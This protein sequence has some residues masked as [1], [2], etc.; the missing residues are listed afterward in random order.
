MAKSGLVGDVPP[1]AN[2]FE[3]HPRLA[4]VLVLSAAG[5]ILAASTEF[6]L[7]RI[8]STG[9]SLLGVEPQ[10]R[11]LTF[12]EYP[13]SGRFGAMPANPREVYP[14]GLEQRRYWIDIDSN[15]FLVP[16]RM[17]A[18]AALEVVFLG[19]STTEGLFVTPERRFPFRVGRMLED[20]LG[21][22]VN[23]YNGGRSGNVS[24]HAV[25]AFL[26][27]VAPMRP[28]YVILMEN[29]NDLAVLTH[30]ADYWSAAS[31]RPFMKQPADAWREDGGLVR[32]FKGALRVLLPNRYG[33]L[34]SA[35]TRATRGEKPV[36]EFAAVRG[37][38][39]PFDLAAAEATFQRGLETF[40]AVA[41]I[42]RTTPVLMT[43]ANRLTAQPDPEIA[44]V[45][46]S[47]LQGTS[48][49]E[50]RH[51]YSRFNDVI[52]RVAKEQGV[53]LVDLDRDLTPDRLDMYDAVHYTDRGSERAAAVIARHLRALEGAQPSS[54]PR[55]DTLR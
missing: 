53:P 31:P 42:W 36:D 22:S 45:W 46:G 21:T 51:R 13:V 12:R 6:A 16:S 26:G 9:Q 34:G 48:Y 7:G 17:H 15:G 41:R 35:W 30:I 52:R 55:R 11:V 28:K 50:F 1:A 4:L 44:A 23:S 25:L 37:K 10:G 47:P 49:A 19:G 8:R 40:V 38:E 43:Q 20:S 54:V 39:P 29:I 18:R 24:R 3:R 14:G 5:I 27:K 32:R 33:A 2:W